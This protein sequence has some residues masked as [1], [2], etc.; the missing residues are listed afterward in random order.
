GRAAGAAGPACPPSAF[1]RLPAVCVCSVS[2]ACAT[3]RT[4]RC[5]GAALD[6][7][8][9]IRLRDRTGLLRVDGVELLG[10][11]IGRYALGFQAGHEFI[12]VDLAI[13]VGIQIAE[14]LGC[15]ARRAL[16]RIE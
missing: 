1:R 4:R 8:L 9:Q 5:E 11:V 6:R 10:G 7:R 13:L 12:L 3:R 2:G 16:R 14:Y 15:K